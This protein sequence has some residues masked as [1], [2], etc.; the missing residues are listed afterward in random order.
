[1]DLS[2]SMLGKNWFTHQKLKLRL[3]NKSGVLLILNHEPVKVYGR[4]SPEYSITDSSGFLL[5][6]DENRVGLKEITR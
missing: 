5:H 3:W 1:M 4:N 6:N 2:H